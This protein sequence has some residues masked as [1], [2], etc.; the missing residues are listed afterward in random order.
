MLE[1]P[2]LRS[3]LASVEPRVVR[4]MYGGVVINELDAVEVD[5][6]LAD[7]VVVADNKLY[8]QGAGWDTIVS[9]VFPFRQSRVGLGVLLRVP[10]NATNKMHEFAIK[11]VDPDD[12]ATV[13]GDAPPGTDLP[14]RKVR[15][16]R[17]QFNVGR[18]PM[19]HAGDSQ[20]VPIALN[21]DGLEFAEPLDLSVVIFID[22][23]PVR[24]MPFRV[25]SL[26]QMPGLVQPPRMPG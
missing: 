8:V 25:R 10:W 23:E 16:L 3:T 22:G 20:V 7:S 14:D 15:E 11:I 6:F 17:G 1:I 9:P 2:V 5:A 19:L 26:V 21:L 24:R 13:L 4:Q 18:P 12:N